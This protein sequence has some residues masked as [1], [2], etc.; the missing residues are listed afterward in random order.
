MRIDAEL[1]ATLWELS[2]KHT[3]LQPPTWEY[4]YTE[5]DYQYMARDEVR[6]RA[7]RQAI[8]QTVKDKT[9]IEIGPGSMLVLTLL[10]VEAGA[11]KIYAIEIDEEAYQQA[12]K[13]VQAK[14]LTDKI[15]LLHGSSLNIDVPEKGDVCI[16]E[17]IGCIG[18]IEGAAV[19]LHNAHRFLKP[20]GVM[21][22]SRCL[23]WLSP[24][25]KP[26]FYQDAFINQ[27]HSLLTEEAYKVAGKRFPFP[28]YSITNFPD[29]NLIAPPQLFEDLDFNDPNLT[30][31]F[32]R[33]LTFEIQHDASFDG[34]LLWIELYVDATTILN[35]WSCETGWA[36]AYLP[37]EPFA[38]K[39]ND[40]MQIAAQ[41]KLT[42]HSFRPDYLF[43]ISVWRQ[44]QLVYRYKKD[45]VWS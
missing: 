37:V 27:A 8:Q 6:N 20:S 24:V 26:E 17:V 21:L 23:T 45:I 39:P 30:T 32:A 12:Q 15:E 14:E 40:K 11:K 36:T 1:G 18:G 13:L 44:S 9:V 16:S 28:Y 25:V 33:N 22:P 29:S 7:Y 34:L 5:T 35:A 10:C 42:S 31:D 4:V 41:S 43:D 2:R 19:L 3:L 38:L